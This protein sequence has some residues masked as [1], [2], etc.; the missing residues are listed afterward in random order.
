MTADLPA[1]DVVIPA[2]NAAATIAASVQSCLSQTAPNLRVI[3]VDDGSTDATAATVRKLAAADSRVSLIHQANA[4]ISAAMNAGIAAGTAPF[5][6]RLDADDLSDPDRHRLQLTRM[7]QQPNIVAL[8]GCYHEITGDGRDT[9]HLH[10]PPERPTADPDWLPAHEPALS[11]PFTMF[12]RTALQRVGL[13]RP[14]PVSE[15]SDLYWRLSTIGTLC[16]LPD[17]IGSYRMHGDSISS[18]SIQNGRRMAICSQLAALSARRQRRHAPDIP[19]SSE[20]LSVLTAPLVL[21]ASLTAL[22]HAL[23]LTPAESAWLVPAV[24]AKLIELSG[25]RPYELDPSDCRFIAAALIPQ[26]LNGLR[27]DP[28]EIDRMRCATAARMLRHGRIR[29]AATLASGDWAMIIA[30]AAT[31]RLYWA[32]RTA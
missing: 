30:R 10:S 7:T 28:A 11:Q 22:C 8:S 29:D 25:Y 32:K 9:G 12:R 17:V 31:G 4:G 21:P 16:N 23:R 24:A 18:V 27:C 14:F 6:A 13:F 5:V 3:V 1:V 19:L 26:K 2:Y 15:D 20:I